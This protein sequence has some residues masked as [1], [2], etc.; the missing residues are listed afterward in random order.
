MYLKAV[1]A[2]GFKS[3]ATKT[4]I[5]FDSGITGVVG[6]NGSGKSN[7]TDAIRWVLGEQSVKNLRGKKMEDVI[8]N[9]AKD[10]TA[11]NFAEVS[12]IL[13]N[14]S[15]SIDVDANVVKITRRL[16]RNGDSEYAVNGEKSRLKDIH[17]LILDTGLG[18]E[19]FSI[20]SQGKVDQILNAKPEERR[21]LIEEAA[22]VL[23]YKKRKKETESRLEQTMNNLSRI[24]DIIF[25]L[26]VRVEPLAEEA[27]I[28]KEYVALTKE[29]T[30]AD[31]HVTVRDIQAYQK[32]YMALSDEL[33]TYTE[34]VLIKEDKLERLKS[35]MSKSKTIQEQLR[36]ETESLHKRTVELTELIERATGQLVLLDEKKGNTK[37]TKARVTKEIESIEMELT[38]KLTQLQ[39]F[40]E[41]QRTIQ[42]TLERTKKEIMSVESSLK[43]END[44]DEE[45]E[46]LR[47]KYYEQVSE[48]ADLKNKERLLTRDLQAIQQWKSSQ[49]VDESVLTMY[50]EKQSQINNCHASLEQL[51]TKLNNTRNAYKEA[52]AHQ[53]HEAAK[54]KTVEEQLYKAYHFIEQLK[55][56]YQSIQAM[57]S[58]YQGYFQGVR[59]VLKEKSLQGIIGSVMELISIDKKYQVALDIALGAQLQHIITT[60]EAAASDAIQYLKQKKL[61]RAT[62]LPLSTIR[63]YKA[64]VD[65]IVLSDLIHVD[66]KYKSVI[67]QL[68][69]R[70]L[71]ADDLTSARALSNETGRKYRIVTLMGDI[72]NPGGSMT[73]GSVNQPS[74]LL[75]QKE[76]AQNLEEK[77]ETY[78]Q[79]TAQLEHQVQEQKE[80]WNEVNERIQRLKEEGESLSEQRL[81]LVYQVGQL[82]NELSDIKRDKELLMTFSEKEQE[83]DELAQELHTLHLQIEKIS[84]SLTSVEEALQVSQERHKLQLKTTSEQQA[85]LNELKAKRAALNE[86]M[87][88][89]TERLMDINN[90]T[91]VIQQKLATLN[92]EAQQLSN[93]DI[94]ETSMRLSSELTELKEEREIIQQEATRC[95]EQLLEINDLLEHQSNEQSEVQRQISGLQNGIG[96]MKNNHGKID[97]KLE[98]LLYHLMEDYHMTFDKAEEMIDPSLNIDELRS[99]VKL[100]KRTIDELGDVNVGAIKEYEQVKERYDFLSTQES[101]LLTAKNNLESIIH[102]MD[103]EVATRFNETFNQVKHHF[104]IV[105][106]ELFGGGTGELLLESDDLLNTGI[107]I[108]IEPPG[109]KRTTLSLLSGGERA[110]T[111]IS[112]LFAILKVRSAPFV[113]LDEVEAAL[114]EANVLRFGKYLK[115]LSNDTQFIVITHRKG[116]MEAVDR[117]YGVT[118]NQTGITQLVSVNLNDLVEGELK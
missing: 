27:A 74:I 3:F 70:I 69:G 79:N 8:F 11:Q 61:G 4:K 97:A 103:L 52:L 102:D 51:D 109:K 7:I 78:T 16:Y 93:E 37:Q 40:E 55:S 18:K 92:E 33:K 89:V 24:S 44:S 2:Q 13:D 54:Y 96:D 84:R 64:D 31:I 87:K 80:R 5:T 113:I 1:E 49:Q 58:E 23:K 112:L 117:L 72:I 73:G 94:H 6:P 105:F 100:I 111:A 104:N 38:N 101:D 63:G 21:Q 115:T 15:K 107:E 88:Y 42:S 114:D 81:E 41:E 29:L 46:S 98:S 28:A 35:K 110:L 75:K 118:M 19:A 77:I 85:I 82:T 62:F 45:I 20:I 17:E 86:R 9:G 66:E 25:D 90:E 43:Q 36:E 68:A 22:G 91:K 59:A 57:Q 60:D 32:E 26:E 65:A 12:L 95:K 56:K 116:T 53:N 76:E 99:K 34:M 48:Q 47:T 14:Q 108:Y 39:S 30:S 10:K 71:V 106:K 67:N 83:A 50:Q